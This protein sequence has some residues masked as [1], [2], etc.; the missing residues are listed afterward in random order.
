MYASPYARPGVLGSRSARGGRVGLDWFWWR[1]LLSWFAI[2]VDLR[3]NLGIDLRGATGDFRHWRRATL[4]GM[5]IAHRI[6]SNG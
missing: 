6:H 5:D 4:L 2:S 1:K 3:M